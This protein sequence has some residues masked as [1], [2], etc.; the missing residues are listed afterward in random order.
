MSWWSPATTI[1]YHP[2][3]PTLKA[4]AKPWKVSLEWAI[5]NQ[6]ISQRRKPYIWMLVANSTRREERKKNLALVIGSIIG[7]WRCGS[8]WTL[9]FPTF[10]LSLLMGWNHRQLGSFQRVRV[11]EEDVLGCASAHSRQG[12]LGAARCVPHCFWNWETITARPLA[13]VY[14]SSIYSIGWSLLFIF[15]RRNA[16]NHWPCA[17]WGCLLVLKPGDIPALL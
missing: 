16:P 1:S 2:I 3:T 7:R 5:R 15:H 14:A 8:S 12:T 10:W 17:L 9:F 6:K 13:S 4:E 11:H